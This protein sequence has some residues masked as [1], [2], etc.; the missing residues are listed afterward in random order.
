M[1][2]ISNAIKNSIVQCSPPYRTVT[3]QKK[4]KNKNT[5]KDP[6]FAI[7]LAAGLRTTP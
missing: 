6:L 7:R 4:K 1:D 5:H 3:S 2:M